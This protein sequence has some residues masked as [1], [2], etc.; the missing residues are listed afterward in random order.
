MSTDSEK[1][2]EFEKVVRN[3]INVLADG[4]KG[5]AEYGSELKD[6]TLKRYFLAE[7]TKRAN[8][9]AELENELH[10][11]GVADVH[12][13]GTVAGSLHRTWGELVSKVT[14][15]DDHSIL[16]NAEK[17][18]DVTKKA[19]SDALAENL[20]QPLRDL[21]SE[22]NAHLVTSHDYVKSHRDALAN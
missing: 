13:N 7:S 18:E 14:G 15:H 8:F 2:T 5:F 1:N 22:Q 21:I 19:Y 9:R 10:R 3:L 4:Q 12:E 20:P 6:E 17:G 16:A 11:H